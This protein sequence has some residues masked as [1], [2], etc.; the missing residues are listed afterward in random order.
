MT[1]A[2]LCALIQG[3]LEGEGGVEITGPA[4]IDKAWPGSVTFLANPKYEDHLYSTQASV[5][6]VSRDLIL[7]QPVKPTLI[8][9]E[10]AYGAMLSLAARFGGSGDDFAGVSPLAVI[11]EGM[12]LPGDAAIGAF[13]VIGQRVRIGKGVRIFP[14]VYIG[15]DVTL[16]D[17]VTLYSGVRIYARTVIGD[18]CA[19]HANAVIGSDGFGYRPD[20]TGAYQKIPH[21][22]AVVLEADVEI[23]ANTV[24][25]RATFGDTRIRRG[26]KIDN[27]VQ[28]AHNVTIG[29]DTVIAAQAGIAGSTSV[30]S[31]SRIGGQVGIVGHLRLA[32]GL[33]IQ[34]QS[35][36]QS[37]K[38]EAGARLYGSPAIEYQAY[39]RA[40]AA[41]KQMPDYIRRINALERELAALKKED[42]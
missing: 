34:A 18:R 7:R 13:A 29:E 22:G 41:F 17:N 32:D 31:R 28:V 12:V 35:G 10:D 16:G 19:V 2:Q 33:E 8:R 26:T 42:S 39:L 15:P 36:V 6:I 1:A 40:Y 37:D 21:T 20:A 27:L 38:N 9:V 5:V 23:G 24:I 3:E 4:Q 30:G 11:P 14:H 25:D